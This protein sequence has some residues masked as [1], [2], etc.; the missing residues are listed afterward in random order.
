MMLF[1]SVLSIM[2]EPCLLQPC[3]HAAGVCTQTTEHPKEYVL[4]CS[5]AGAGTTLSSGK[6]VPRKGVPASFKS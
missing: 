5:V 6:G 3:V 1:A 4:R 2:L